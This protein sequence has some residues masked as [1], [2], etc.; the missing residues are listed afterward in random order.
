[1]LCYSHVVFVIGEWSPNRNRKEVQAAPYFAR[2]GESL[3]NLAIAP[4]VAGCDEVS[5][6]AALQEGG[7]RD[8]TVCAEELGEGNHLHEAETDHCCLGVVAK[9]QA[10]TEA[11]SHCHNVLQ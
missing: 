10:I 5:D 9:S 1:M 7:G 3:S 4:S 2:F 6:A 11:C 8:E